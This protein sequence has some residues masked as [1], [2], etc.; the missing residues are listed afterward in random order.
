MME[1]NDMNNEKH[2]ARVQAGFAGEAVTSRE[3]SQSEHSTQPDADQPHRL[4]VQIK[5]GLFW[6]G[7]HGFLPMGIATWLMQ[8]LRLAGV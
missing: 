8:A 6:L 2:K 1:E 4:A 7:M 5:R 3:T